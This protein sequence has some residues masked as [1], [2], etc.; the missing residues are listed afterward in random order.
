MRPEDVHQAH[1]PGAGP[2]PK[3]D[4]ALAARAELDRQTGLVVQANLRSGELALR[5]AAS[6]PLPQEARALLGGL[7]DVMA[8]AALR[9]RGGEPPSLTFGLPSRIPWTGPNLALQAAREALELA[10][11]V[12]ERA[13][14]PLGRGAA[15]LLREGVRLASGARRD[16]KVE[17]ALPLAQRVAFRGLLDLGRKEA[18]VAARLPGLEVRLGSRGAALSWRMERLQLALVAGWGARRQGW[19]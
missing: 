1:Q 11:R 13:E 18:G 3:W 10:A 6:L 2:G 9:V 12:A 17:V 19:R 8:A 5:A 4:L 14:D 15:A 7:G 16:F